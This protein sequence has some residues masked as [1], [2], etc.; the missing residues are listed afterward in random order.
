MHLPITIQNQTSYINTGNYFS[1]TLLL[2]E[3]QKEKEEIYVVVKTEKERNIFE[4]MGR[5]LWYKTSLWNISQQ[6]IY[7]KVGK[8]IYFLLESD[9]EKYSPKKENFLLLESEKSYS[10]FD[11]LEQIHSYGY[12]FDEFWKRWS[13]KRNGDIISIRSFEGSDEYVL[14]FWGDTLESIT[15]RNWNDDILLSENSTSSLILA[16]NEIFSTEEGDNT[17]ISYLDNHGAFFVFI[18]C[19][20]LPRYEKHITKL[21]S[22]ISFDILEQ[23]SR[24]SQNLEVWEL[25]IENLEQLKEF[26]IWKAWKKIIYIKNEKIIQEFLDY[27]NIPNIEVRTHTSGHH[28][29]SFMS[30]SLTI[31][32]DDILQKLFIKRRVKRKLTEDIDLLLKVKEGD[33]IVHIDH[34]IGIF[35]GIV[36]KELGKTIKEYMEIS[37]KDGEK[38]FVPI[39]EVARV[40]KYVWDENPKLTWLNGKVWEKKIAKVREDI[41]HIA[42]E[43]LDTFAKRKIETGIS[44]HLDTKK[45][46]N[47]QSAFP[48]T[49]TEDQEQAIQDIFTDMA[50]DTPMER[51]VVWDVG[52]WKTEVAF[53]AAFNAIANKK[54]AILLSP[55]VVLAYEHYEKALERFS[56]MW[57][58]IEIVS[59]LTSQRELTRIKKWI[60]EGR[61]DF[62]IGTHKLLSDSIVYKDLWLIIIDEEH[63]FWVTD[64][65]KIKNLTSHIDV[66]SLSATPIPRSLNMA[67]SG[68]RDI[69]LLKTP[70]IG[71]KDIQTI[72]SRYDEAVIK[73][74][75]KRE[76]DRGWQVFFIHNRVNNIEVYQK[77]LQK[78]FPKKKII[79]THGQLPWDELEKRI[80]DF[81]YKKYDILVSTT[82][83]ENGI[84]FSNVNTIFI[85]ECQGFGISQIHQLRWRVWRS[86]IQW[87]CYLLYRKNEL[88]NEVAK[89]LKT[90][91]EYSYLWA[92]FEL[93]MKDLE[94]RWWWD[95]L[96]IR[97][98]GQVQEIGVT[99]F[100]KMLEEKIEEIKSWSDTNI[101]RKTDIR[102][103]KIDLDINSFIPDEFFESETDK[104]NFYREIETLK[105]LEELKDIEEDFER[106]NS[107][108]SSE[109]KN[110]FKLLRIKILAKKYSIQSI[111]RVGIN[112]QIDFKKG[113]A[114]DELKAFLKLDTEVMFS[115]VDISRIRTPVKSFGNAEKFL[116]YLLDMLQ[117]KVSKKKKIK[118]KR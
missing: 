58:H 38:L 70:P 27:N 65:E 59:R 51:L 20:L 16:S 75:A 24:K 61:I 29:K 113:I 28:I 68:I 36:K 43:I 17:C 98:S 15:I 53:N 39:T 40:S 67:L 90:I 76:F 32:C 92:G 108:I 104:L 81:K 26:L 63:K 93:A 69:S 109:S 64:K 57:I 89:R 87:Y 85:N 77:N 18:E 52:F 23:T 25:R 82:V 84:D 35:E 72:I 22:Y 12:D 112:Y 110:L 99:L 55:L 54:Q 21:H 117:K 46:Q 42:E 9:L 83:I 49:Y 44:F 33:Y 2:W 101:E 13:Y 79:I 102:D 91:A 5:F 19:D 100:M 47:F 73:E 95:I 14:S 66:L 45:I 118:L 10:I 30:P 106:M 8:K 60:L 4:K 78:L 1:Q 56:W 116:E 107:N 114:L 37:Y 111:K 88:D 41:Q 31:L 6:D 62:V 80:L 105:E 34:G 103:I 7:E 86:D 50:K 3:I 94:I 48:Y 115:V 97:Q 74:A 11:L 96:G 71:R